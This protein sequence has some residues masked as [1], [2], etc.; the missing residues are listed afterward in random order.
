MSFTVEVEVEVNVTDQRGNDVD[1]E[2]TVSGSEIDIQLDAPVIDIPELRDQL[3]SLKEK[4]EAAID[5]LSQ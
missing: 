2:V 1:H 5:A 4:I 3:E